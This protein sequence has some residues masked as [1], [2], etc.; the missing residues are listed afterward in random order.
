ML[1]GWDIDILTEAEESERRQKEIST[2]SAIFMEALDVDDVIAHLLVAEG[3]TSIEELVDTPS[4][5]LN[6]IEGFSEEISIELQARAQNYLD[7]KKKELQEKQQ[8]LGIT[9]DLIELEGMKPAF[10]IKLGDA[11]VKTRDDLADLAGDEL[12]DILGEDKITEAAANKMIMK[13]REHWFA[14]ENESEQETSEKSEDDTTS[15]GKKPDTE[16]TDNA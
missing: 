9:D 15:E 4:S 12:V 6:D 13:A 1:L 3:F 10:A 16:S 2:R 5:E 7:A 11:G 14:D 8:K